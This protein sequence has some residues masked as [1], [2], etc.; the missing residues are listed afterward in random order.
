MRTEND[1]MAALRSLAPP[2]PDDA[3]VLRGVRRRVARRRIRRAGGLTGVTGLAA[4]ITAVAVVTGSAP[5][6]AIAGGHHPPAQKTTTQR[7]Q[8]AAYIVRHAAAAEAR[9]ARMIQVTRDSAG[10]SYMSVATQR[11][12]FVSSRRT[13]DGQPLLASAESIKGTTYTN[14]DVD[15]KDRAY[16]VNSASTLDG[17]PSGAK[18]IVI[19]SW[20]PGV[21][22]S[23]PASAYTAALRKGIIKVIGYRKLN[24][25]Q[26]ILIQVD[27]QKVKDQ[28]APPAQICP[29]RHAGAPS[30][31]GSASSGPSIT[32]CGPLPPGTVTCKFVP[33]GVDEVWLDASTYLEVQEATIAPKTVGGTASDKL[34][35]CA[36]VVGWS[37]TTRS[38]DWLPPTRHNLALLNLTPPAGF[39]Q[40]SNQ[41]MAQYLGPYS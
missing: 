20:L 39:T 30:S 22:A 25:R 11:T 29:A 1:L 8:T 34:P 4:A 2:A 10:V 21:T 15:Y 23:D 13:S 17:G 6:P 26:T 37:T 40:V 19:G 9:A 33:L 14:M 5:G 36:K 35:T 7:A 3:A 18:G 41:Q 16:T 24:G 32:P 28:N 38:V 12:V 27:F 31:S